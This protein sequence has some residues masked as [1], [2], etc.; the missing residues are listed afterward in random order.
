MGFPLSPF[1]HV[2]LLAGG[3]TYDEWDL[4]APFAGGLVLDFAVV[5]G[6]VAAVVR[7][8]HLRLS[9]VWLE[10]GLVV[11]RDSLDC[12]L[13]TRSGDAFLYHRPLSVQ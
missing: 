9:L 6:N 12:G 3:G 8:R 10:R 2:C 4:A 5:A 7:W 1:D 11:W 13:A